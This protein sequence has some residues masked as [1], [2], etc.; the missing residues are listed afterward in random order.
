MSEMLP[1]MFEA[2][3]GDAAQAMENATGAEARFLEQT[4]ANEDLAVQ[5]L[6]DTDQQIAN[7]AATIGERASL[8]TEADALPASTVAAQAGTETQDRLNIAN[9]ADF[10]PEILRGLSPA[11]IR[12][13]IPSS[14]IA[15]SSKSGAGEVFRDPANPGRQ[16]RIMPGYPTGTRPDILATGSYAVVSQNGMVTKVPLSGNPVL[17]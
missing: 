10:E 6:L 8:D 15:S 5:R 12:A 7:Q 1:E 2:L 11:E 9:P 3:A 4:A 13:E 16:I 14:W 17:P